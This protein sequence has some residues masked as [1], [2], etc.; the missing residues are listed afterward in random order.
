MN[1]PI[2][3]DDCNTDAY[4]GRISTQPDNTAHI[5]TGFLNIVLWIE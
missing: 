5:T 3:K 1:L 2:A 4:G